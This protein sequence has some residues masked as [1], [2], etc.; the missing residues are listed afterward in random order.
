MYYIPFS[1][2]CQSSEMKREHRIC[3]ADQKSQAKGECAAAHS[4]EPLPHGIP[5][6]HAF[7]DGSDFP[8]PLIP[9]LFTDICGGDRAV[10]VPDGIHDFRLAFSRSF[11]PILHSVKANVLE[12]RL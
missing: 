10:R 5:P 11:S 1:A 3:S 6:R 4:K 7:Q 12:I 8:V 9:Y 2:A